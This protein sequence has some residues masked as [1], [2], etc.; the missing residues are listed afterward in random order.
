MA[1]E[2]EVKRDFKVLREVIQKYSKEKKAL[3]EENE[4]IEK[5]LSETVNKQQSAD[6]FIRNIKKYL[7]APE[8]T[9]EMCYE[10][11]DRIIV[12]GS[13]KVTGKERTIDIVYKVDI[14]SVLRYKLNKKVYG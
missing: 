1:K 14:D 2:V 9:R 11:I 3:A 4:T 7:D 10:L 6:D 5:Q 8:L 12:S 13:P